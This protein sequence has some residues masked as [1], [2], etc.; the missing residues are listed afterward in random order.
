MRIETQTTVRA[1]ARTAYEFFSWLD[2]LALVSPAERREWCPVPGQRI[3][4]GAGREVVLEQ[5]RHR[6]RLGFTTRR[7]RPGEEIVDVFTSWPLDGARRAVEFRAEPRAEGEAP[8]TRISEVHAWR[9]PFYLR[10]LV[11]GRLAKQRAMFDE[12]LARAAQLI[13]RGYDAFGPD[14]FAGGVLE[15]ARALGFGPR[16][17][18][19]S[20]SG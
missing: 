11:E 1:P 4:E 13:A 18:R 3:A 7:L 17:S 14:V 19:R 6:V 8:V 15:P 2:H 9:P 5:G 16:A 10:P 20:M 12:R